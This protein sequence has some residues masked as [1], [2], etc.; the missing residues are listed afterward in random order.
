MELL[1]KNCLHCGVQFETTGAARFKRIF[2][3]RVC[4][5]KSRYLKNRDKEVLRAKK[6]REE[7]PEKHRQAVDN[8]NKNNP[9]RR[10]FNAIR[11]QKNNPEKVKE[12]RKRE[13]EKNWERYSKSNSL[14]RK[15]NFEQMS[16]Y[17]KEWI[18]NNRGKVNAYFAKRRVLRISATPSYANLAK[19]EE[20]YKE[21][22]RLTKETGIQHHV[23]HIVP[24]K[25]KTVSGLHHEDNLQILTA[26]ENLI[27]HN[28]FAFN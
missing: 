19:I 11:W 7:N 4:F 3:S 10:I 18:N 2:C 27:K 22:A 25:G 20:I 6:Y 12:I 9:E 8:W 14:Y 17:K 1:V 28:K 13:Y 26:T 23:D 24:L 5:R 15:K 16:A 21:A